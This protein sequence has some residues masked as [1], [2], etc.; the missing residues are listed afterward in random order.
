MWWPTGQIRLQLASGQDD[1][2]DD[3]DDAYGDGDDDDGSGVA[4]VG[5]HPDSGLGLHGGPSPL[6][7]CL[8]GS[9]WPSFYSYGWSAF[10]GSLRTDS[11]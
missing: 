1:A 2:I 7:R 4:E 10:V 11:P 3:D 9:G 5:S 6:C 8:N